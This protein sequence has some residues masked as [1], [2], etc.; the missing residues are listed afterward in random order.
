MKLVTASAMREADRTTMKDLGFPGIALME[1]AGMRVTEAIMSIDPLPRR[2]VI[3]VGPGNNGGDGLVVA[4]HLDRLGFQ[5]SVWSTAPKESYSGD[6]G[7]N[8]NFLEKKGLYVKHIQDHVQL[9]MVEEDIH[10]AD[11]VVD[12]LLGT[13]IGRPVE[14]MIASL[15]GVLNSSWIPVLSVDIPSGI[16]ADT[17]EVR[18]NA[19]RAWW[20]ITFAYPKRGLMLYPGADHAGWVSVAEIDIPPEALPPEGLEVITPARIYRLLPD[21]PGNAHKGTFGKIMIVAGSPGMTGA[22]ALAGE[23]ALRGGGGLVYV[24]TSQ[25]LRQILEAKTL[26]VIT[27]DLPETGKGEISDDAANIILQK[28][29]NCHVLAVGPGMTPGEETYR[30]LEELIPDCPVPMILDAGAL[31]ALAQGPE[32]LLKARAPVIITPHPGEM[33]RLTGLQLAEVE[34]DRFALPAKIARSWKTVV[35]MKGAPTVISLPN[36]LSY[37]NPTGGPALATAGT[38]DVLTGLI[39]GL[40]G[41]G[42]PV[43]EAALCGAFIHG[44]AGDLAASEGRGI[45]AGD[46]LLHFPATFKTLESRGWESSIFGPFHR[47]LRP[48][49]RRD[50]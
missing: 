46:V 30:L 40:V 12:A 1:N 28:A 50:S 8:L 33:S 14:G 19:V 43:E 27:M 21:R 48:R 3:L 6:P 25:R 7:I 41:Q 45:K 31:G 24:A 29:A 49:F 5:L 32:I 18:G 26:E 15:I 42:L 10:R 2:V 9:G 20:T 36:G 37:V 34:R 16:D 11:L 23:A 47:D 4:R 38:G 17:G 13:G 22:A 44:V 35:V 39:A